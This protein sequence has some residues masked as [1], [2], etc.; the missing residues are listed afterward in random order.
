MP[1]DPSNGGH[2]GGKPW[3]ASSSGGT[4]SSNT[5]SSSSSSSSSGGGAVAIEA[6]PGDASS[7]AAPAAPALAPTLSRNALLARAAVAVDLPLKN[8]L[9]LAPGAGRSL[10]AGAWLQKLDLCALAADLV[11]GA[12]E[13]QWQDLNT[14]VSAAGGLVAAPPPG[15][16]AATV[17]PAV[18]PLESLGFGGRAAC[19]AWAQG[20]LLAMRRA[21]ARRHAEAFHAALRE[22]AAAGGGRFLDEEVVLA[23]AADARGCRSSFYRRGGGDAAG[24]QRRPVKRVGPTAGAEAAVGGEGSDGGGATMTV[25]DICSLGTVVC[26][27]SADW[28]G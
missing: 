2:S 6:A 18:R 22:L 1:D 3:E 11:P 7:A 9:P 8:G 12:S 20:W 21:D 26:Q 10:A 5:S 28:S 27:A 15:A 17:Y 16:L 4:S 23:W 13:V 19:A 25:V 24:G 14:R